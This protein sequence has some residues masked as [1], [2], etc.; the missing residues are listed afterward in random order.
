MIFDTKNFYGKGF[1]PSYL[2]IQ[3]PFLGKPGAETSGAS[4]N[5]V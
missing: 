5:F 1:K 4:Y 3:F 2:T